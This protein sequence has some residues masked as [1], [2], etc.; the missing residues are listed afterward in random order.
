VTV[1]DMDFDASRIDHAWPEQDL[2]EVHRC[3]YCDSSERAL[4][5]RDVQDWSFYCA[6]GKWTYWRC[7]HC[8]SLYLSPR[9][10]PATLGRA[11]R[12]YYTHNLAQEES[13][14]QWIKERLGN[15]CWSQWLEVD[16]RPRLRLPRALHWLLAPLKSRLVEPFEIAELVKLPRGRLM[17]VG[18]GSGR[19]LSIAQHLGW[20]AVGLDIDP[21]AARAAQARGLEVLVGSYGRLADFRNELDCIICSHV[22]EHVHDPRDFLCKVAMALKPGGTLLLSLPNATS[23]VRHYFGDDWRGLEAPRHLTIPSMAQLKATLRDM[24][25][26]VR[27]R[28]APRLWTVAESSRIRRR[29]TRLNRRD[30][31]MERNL[32]ADHAPSHEEQDDFVE[33]VCVN[34]ERHAV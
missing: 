26:S 13:F 20:H 10:T 16:I 33:F 7:V 31:A 27:Q 34:G 5:H 25:F 32:R 22:L 29:G 30:R 4:A 14:L 1:V 8:D 19:L 17:D 24:G 6:P 2:E 21:I 11:Y 18:C 9:P 12:T 28:H 15:E 3:P 23:V